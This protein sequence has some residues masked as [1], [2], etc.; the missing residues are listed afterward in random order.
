MQA[1]I[2]DVLQINLKYGEVFEEL[3]HFCVTQRLY[4]E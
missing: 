1:S 4:R 2:Q 3:G